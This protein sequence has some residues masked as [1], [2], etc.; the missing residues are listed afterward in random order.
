[1]KENLSSQKGN[2]Q[3]LRVLIIE[4][5]E[6]DV[7]LVAR[8]LKKG[9]YEPVY[10]RIE[11]AAAMKKALQDREWDVIL[12][13]YNMPNFKGPSAIALLKEENIDIPVIMV[14]GTIGEEKAVECMRLG[15]HDYIMK[16]NYSRLCPVIARELEESKIRKKQKETETQKK[17]ALEQLRHSEERYR[18]ITQCIPD[19]IWIMD[20]SGRFIYVNEAVERTHGWTVDEF[21]NLSLQDLVS[22]QQI[23]KDT[24][25]LAEQLVKANEPGFDRN[26]AT[27]TF[28]SEEL[29]KDGS[30]FWAEV[31]ATFLWSEDGK[32]NGI[33]GVTR[34]ITERKLTHE[35]LKESEKKYK[36]LTEKMTDIVWMADMNL[37]VTYITPSVYR[38]LGFRIASNKMLP[39]DWIKGIR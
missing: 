33:I 26:K 12:C 35:F 32:P 22:P 17:A 20:L 10:E 30:T 27:L 19:L 1:M 31:T 16:G 39:K 28:E 9:G 14:S 8:E 37:N 25:M 36:L 34:D 2:S 11:T 5:S 21:L 4:D 3:T 23:A 29:R 7:L 24:A 13:D 38:V 15:A 18:K 6:D